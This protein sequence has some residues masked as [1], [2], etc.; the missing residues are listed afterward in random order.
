M[1]SARARLL[2]TT[3][4]RCRINVDV[5]PHALEQRIA[6]FGEVQASWRRDHG[7]N[8]RVEIDILGQASF[9]NGDLTAHDDLFVTGG[10]LDVGVAQAAEIH[11]R[12]EGDVLKP[13]CEV[14]NRHGS[15]AHLH[16]SPR[17]TALRR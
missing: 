3:I 13:Q 16:R 15:G 2:S 17:Q 5:Q 1:I 11:R 9:L 8:A 12:V 10:C 4:R 6:R 7:K 14:H